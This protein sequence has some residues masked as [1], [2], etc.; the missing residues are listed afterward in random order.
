[1]V[2]HPRHMEASSSQQN[3]NV[4]RSLIWIILGIIL[5]I[6]FPL[7]APFVG[8]AFIVYGVVARKRAGYFHGTSIAMIGAGVLLLCLVI[9]TMTLLVPAQSGGQ[10]IHEAVPA[11]PINP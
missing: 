1:M 3:D 11:I 10:P 4:G 2:Q 8:I 9:A 7:V 6:V 5:S